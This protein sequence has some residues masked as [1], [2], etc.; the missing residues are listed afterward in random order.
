MIWSPNL[1]PVLLLQVEVAE[2]FA[3]P[4]LVEVATIAAEVLVSAVAAETGVR[5][6]V[7]RNWKRNHV[8]AHRLARAA[9][10]V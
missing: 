2:C 7:A 4:Q 3:A 5:V 8:T 9:A 10:C 6:L 1:A